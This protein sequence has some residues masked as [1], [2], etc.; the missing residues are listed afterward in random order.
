MRSSKEKYGQAQTAYEKSVMHRSRR[1]SSRGFGVECSDLSRKIIYENRQQRAIITKVLKGRFYEI[2][3]QDTPEHQALVV[4]C[5]RMRRAA[6]KFRVLVMM[7]LWSCHLTI[8]SR[9]RIDVEARLRNAVGEKTYSIKTETALTF[10]CADDTVADILCASGSEVA[11]IQIT[12][13]TG[14]T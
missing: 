14:R 5:G 3:L 8:W 9:G 13:P 10:R 4:I 7:C 6:D 12:V 1:I 11:P 2:A